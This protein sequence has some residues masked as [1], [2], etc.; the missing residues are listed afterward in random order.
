MF[1]SPDTPACF[2]LPSRGYRGRSLRKPCGSPP[3]SVLWG[4]KTAQPSIRNPS[5]RPC[6]HVPL[7]CERRWGRVGRWR[8]SGFEMM[9]PFPSSPLRFRTVSF[10]Q[11]GSKVG[12][13]DDA[14]PSIASSSHRAV[15]FHPSCTSLPVTSYPRSESRDAV[16]WYTTVQAALPLY[17]R[18]PRSS[19]VML[20]RP[21]PLNRPHAPHSPAHF[22]FTFKAYTKCPRCASR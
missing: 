11:S 19:R 14:F 9:P 16:R 12:M 8:E 17:P 6:G 1:P 21:S 18:G 22:D 15:C 7:R 13:S 5:G 10:P 3:S 20:S 4:R 2:P